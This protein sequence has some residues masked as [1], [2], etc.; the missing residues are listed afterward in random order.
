MTGQ[1]LYDNRVPLAAK[2]EAPPEGYEEPVVG[3]KIH[4]YQLGVGFRF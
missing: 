2:V 1:L 4:H 3:A